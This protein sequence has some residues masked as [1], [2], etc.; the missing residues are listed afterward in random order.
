MVSKMKI[1]I[2]TIVDRFMKILH[3]KTF[4]IEIEDATNLNM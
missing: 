3:G 4:S 2:M 1:L